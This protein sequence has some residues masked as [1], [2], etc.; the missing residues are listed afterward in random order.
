[1]GLAG[2][3]QKWWLSFGCNSFIRFEGCVI[4]TMSSGNY[5]VGSGLSIEG[6]EEYVEPNLERE[7]VEVV[8]RTEV[9]YET[10]RPRYKRTSGVLVSVTGEGRLE[11]AVNAAVLQGVADMEEEDW[12]AESS[13]EPFY[14]AENPDYEEPIVHMLGEYADDETATDLFDEYARDH[15]SRAIEWRLE[16]A[17]ETF[18]DQVTE[19][20]DRPLS[21]LGD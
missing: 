10:G 21:E 5:I 15:L 11:D 6:F 13:A 8:N 14:L 16:N 18:E 7:G 1:M 19:L 9:P 12:D 2:V 20:L 3:A 17:V 4:G